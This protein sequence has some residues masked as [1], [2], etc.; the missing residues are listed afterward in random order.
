MSRY[1]VLSCSKVSVG[2]PV[3]FHTGTRS[4]VSSKPGRFQPLSN[5]Y[6]YNQFSVAGGKNPLA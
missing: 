1:G 5:V 4:M 2:L 6:L 3:D